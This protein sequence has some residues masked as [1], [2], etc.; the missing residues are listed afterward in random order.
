[1]TLKIVFDLDGTLIDSVPHIHHAANQGLATHGFGE[2]TLEQA[3]GFV[4]HGLGA[5]IAKARAALGI[6]EALQGSL[7]SSV[8]DFYQQEAHLN[9]PYPAVPEVLQGLSEDGC[10]LGICTNKPIAATR[11]VLEH[12]QW[13]RF[14]AV[15]LGGDSL[16]V[17]K[18][19]PA[20]LLAAFDAL[21]KGR[22]V[23]VGDSEV[24]AETAD[25]AGVPFFLFTQGYRKTPVAELYHTASFDD[26]A[27]L[28]AL[29][30]DG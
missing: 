3:R 20:P 29:L 28:P 1:M 8:M 9:E 11:T 27:A 2:L 15:I 19:D 23:Y 10:R 25:R 22:P 26:F 13:D 18:P 4:G 21:G 12:L 30:E 5:F 7:E 17:R 16:P 24:D 14:F 6:P